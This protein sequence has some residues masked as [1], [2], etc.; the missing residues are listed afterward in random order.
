MPK[1]IAVLVGLDVHKHFINVAHA[2][3]HR[4]DPLVFAGSI[5]SWKANSHKLVWRFHSKAAHLASACEAG[6]SGATTRGHKGD[7]CLF[8]SSKS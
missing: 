5:G 6:P 3:A 4:S 1:R 8:A 2:E 7:D